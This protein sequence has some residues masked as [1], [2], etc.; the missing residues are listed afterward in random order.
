[1]T[2]K[3][4]KSEQEWLEELGPKTYRLVRQKGT[5][6]PGTGAYYTNEASGTYLCVACGEPL[7]DATT[8]YH[9][10]SGWPSFFAPLESEAILEAPDASLGVARTEILC[11]SCGGHLGHVFPDG[12]YPTGLRYCVNSGC[13]RFVPK[14]G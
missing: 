11:A 8:K 12:P 10:G 2:F 4:Q 6:Y 3:V 7:F 1:M 14:E 5:E 9:S 13:M